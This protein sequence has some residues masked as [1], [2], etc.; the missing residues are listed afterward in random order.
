MINQQ[1]MNGEM[2]LVYDFS[3]PSYNQPYKPNR[4]FT[5][6][7]GSGQTV[8]N[9]NPNIGNPAIEFLNNRGT[10]QGNQ[11]SAWKPPV[12][13]DPKEKVKYVVPPFIFGGSV[14][15]PSNDFEKRFDQIMLECVMRINQVQAEEQQRLAQLGGGYFGG[16]N[17]YGAPYSGAYYKIEQIKR[18]TQQK[19]D[20]LYEE[21]RRNRIEL[22]VR[23][24][25]LCHHVL[26]DGVTEERI[27]DWYTGK[28]IESEYTTY[29]DLDT[30]TKTYNLEPYDGGASEFRALQKSVSDEH[31][32]FIPRTANMQQMFEGIDEMNRAEARRAELHKRRNMTNSYRDEDN[33]GYKFLLRMSLARRTGIDDPDQVAKSGE[34]SQFMQGLRKK[35][36]K[37]GVDISGFHNEEETNPYSYFGIKID[38]AVSSRVTDCVVETDTA[39]VNNSF[40][41]ENYDTQENSTSETK[42]EENCTPVEVGNETAMPSTSLEGQ[43][44]QENRT[45]DGY[46][47][48]GSGQNDTVYNAS[49]FQAYEQQE[50]AENIRRLKEL[51]YSQ[52]QIDEIK[53]QADERAMRW[54]QDLAMKAQFIRR[55]MDE[56]Q[57]KKLMSDSNFKTLSESSTIG[58]DGSVNI[59]IN[60]AN[61][62]IRKD[63]MKGGDNPHYNGDPTMKNLLDA[64]Q[65][66]EDLRNSIGPPPD[67]IAQ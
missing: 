13:K 47:E 51:G 41:V 64:L 19:I 59:S 50:L 54:N 8:Q 20:A 21:A 23:L 63:E 46:V 60:L 18:E 37:E 55:A 22:N 32:K 39:P 61:A 40:M 11:Q 17:F 48:K 5:Y 36:M 24:S 43:I 10:Y 29:G 31:D 4:E 62:R 6:Q 1:F 35:Y 14:Y 12:V 65:N 49:S 34:T 27:R 58:P 28:T 25:K 30:Y 67:E 16:F 15:L 42:I 56:I 3:Q 7:N 52:E 45:P 26:K 38:D 2:N 9:M 44:V 53:R 57:A 33:D 66:N